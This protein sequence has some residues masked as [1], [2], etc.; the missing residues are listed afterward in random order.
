MKSLWELCNSLKSDEYEW[1]DLTHDLEADTPHWYGFGN[2]TKETIFDFSEDCIFQCD[3]YTIPS[4]QY[5]THVD[6]P[7]HFHKGAR[8]MEKISLKEMVYPLVVI[9]KSAACA[10]NPDYEL[11]IGDVQE[12]EEQYGKIPEGAFVAFR[13]DWY[14][15]DDMNNYDKDNKPHY[16]GWKPEA[17]KWLVEN[18]HIGSIG[19]EPGDTDAPA[20]PTYLQG[21]QY[22]LGTDRIQVEFMRNLDLVPPVGAIIFVTFPKVKKGTGFPARVFAIYKK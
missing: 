5:G 7:A 14:K 6:V 20:S 17:I 9:D 18:R 8:S 4:G 16:P 15:R 12:F 13:S 19:H 1:I 10:A 21:E 2:L 11:T 22:I 3:K